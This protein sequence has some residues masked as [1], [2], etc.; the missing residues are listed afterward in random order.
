[1]EGAK[2]T[3]HCSATGNPAPT[4]TWTKDGKNVESG[5]VLSFETNRNQSGEYVCSAG[6][7][8][9]VNANASA[10]LDVLCEYHVGIERLD[11]YERRISV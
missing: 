8:L 5:E 10:F 11:C 4:I 6:N 9:N 3:F 1:M 2:V 7:G